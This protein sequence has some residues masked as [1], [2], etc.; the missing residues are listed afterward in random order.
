MDRSTG[1]G[2]LSTA[3]IQP[4]SSKVAQNLRDIRTLYILECFIF[5]LIIEWI[6]ICITFKQIYMDRAAIYSQCTTTP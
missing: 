4:P 2:Q 5:P 6:S 3:N 1:T